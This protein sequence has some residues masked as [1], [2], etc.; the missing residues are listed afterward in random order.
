MAAHHMADCLSLS[1]A[2]G[3]L[4]ALD[5]VYGVPGVAILADTYLYTS[6]PPTH[7][8]PIPLLFVLLG[9]VLVL[10]ALVFAVPVAALAVMVA[11]RRHGRW[12]A[13]AWGLV[14]ALAAG[15]IYALM[16]APEGL[17][18]WLAI[19][20]QSLPGTRR[21]IVVAG[22]ALLLP[23]S[24]LVYGFCRRMPSRWVPVSCGIVGALMAAGLIVAR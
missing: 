18:Q 16:F 10:A 3:I 1:L 8:V 11:V 24:A 4:A 20:G 23:L 14:I 21:G 22:V 5:V 12:I 2:L 9:G 6:A 13:A 7:F 17:R 15:A 19:T